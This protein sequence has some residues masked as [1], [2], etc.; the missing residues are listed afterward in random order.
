[1]ALPSCMTSTGLT[2]PRPKKWAHILLTI[3]RAKNGFFGEV[4]HCASTGR[5][6]SLGFILGCSPSKDLAGTIWADSG[7]PFLPLPL[8]VALS[9]T[10]IGMPFLAACCGLALMR[11]FMKNAAIAQYSSC[12]QLTNGWLWHW[13]H[14]SRTPR[15]MRVTESVILSGVGLA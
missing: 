15:N 13:A 6:G 7:R 3:A 10:S 9:V 8:A 4:S 11:T 2:M 14:S 1:G 5:Y 12:F